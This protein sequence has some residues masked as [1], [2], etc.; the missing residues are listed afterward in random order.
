MKSDLEVNMIETRE[1]ASSIMIN[2]DTL[3]ITGGHHFIEGSPM[4]VRIA[5]TE[6]LS[7]SDGSMSGPG[8]DLPI[9]V[10]GHCLL[11]DSDHGVILTGGVSDE[12][13]SSA[14]SYMFDFASSSWTD[15][16]LFSFILI[17][18]HIFVVTKPLT[19]FISS[20]SNEKKLRV[21]NCIQTIPF[22]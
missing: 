16:S 15:V 17:I 6:Y 3:W 13:Y 5:S 2:P 14:R 21:S 11:A 10:W 4:A 7:I 22:H 18:E 20:N 12:H 8:P 9:H 19:P 1:D